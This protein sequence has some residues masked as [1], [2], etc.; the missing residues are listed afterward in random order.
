MRVHLTGGCEREDFEKFLLALGDG[1][2]KEKEDRIEI[3]INLCQLVSDV[4][5][6][7]NL[8]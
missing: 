6:F 2:L 3:A 4:V 5:E 1:K 8:I 7:T